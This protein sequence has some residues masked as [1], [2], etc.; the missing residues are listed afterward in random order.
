MVP[1]LKAK[2]YQIIGV[3]LYHG[4]QWGGVR[5]PSAIHSPPSPVALPPCFCFG[6]YGRKG[7]PWIFHYRLCFPEVATQEKTLTFSVLVTLVAIEAPSV[8]LPSVSALVI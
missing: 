6:A 1:K 7:D 2:R 5:W 4:P 8:R 3:F